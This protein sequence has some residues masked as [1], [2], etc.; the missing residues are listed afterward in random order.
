MYIYVK[1]VNK[2]RFP[3]LKVSLDQ[4]CLHNIKNGAFTTL[5]K[6]TISIQQPKEKL[7]FIISLQSRRIQAVVWSES[8]LL[9]CQF[10]KL[11]K[12]ENLNFSFYH[13]NEY[14][15]CGKYLLT[16]ITTEAME[17][18]YLSFQHDFYCDMQQ[19]KF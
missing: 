6:L 16:S 10:W 9:S 3:N 1:N 13:L 19:E 17:N 8:G 7:Y 18:L 11:E 2:N 5:A 12:I 14:Y 4:L 15:A